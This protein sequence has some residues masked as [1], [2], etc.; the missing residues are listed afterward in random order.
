MLLSDTSLHPTSDRVFLGL[1]FRSGV[2]RICLLYCPYLPSCVPNLTSFDVLSN[3]SRPVSFHLTT[4]QEP[5]IDTGPSTTSPYL[6]CL[7]AHLVVQ[8]RYMLCHTK[9]PRLKG[10]SHGTPHPP[11]SSTKPRRTRGQKV[12]TSLSV[13]ETILTRPPKRTRGRVPGEGRSSRRPSYSPKDR[14]GDMFG[15]LRKQSVRWG[16]GNSPDPPE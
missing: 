8:L 16:Q 4:T 2:S 5:L 10:N 7:K 6:P 14:K 12:E 9:T 11:L 1:T 15:N 3:A 13:H